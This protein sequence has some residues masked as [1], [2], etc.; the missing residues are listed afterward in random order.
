MQDPFSQISQQ[1]NM[2]NGALLFVSSQERV[3]ESGWETSTA[4]V[5]GSP[6]SN[7]W[8][9]ASVRAHIDSKLASAKIQPL[10]TSEHYYRAATL[11]CA[12]AVENMRALV[13]EVAPVSGATLLLGVDFHRTIYSEEAMKKVRAILL[14]AAAQIFAG[15]DLEKR[16]GDVNRVKAPVKDGSVVKVH[17]GGRFRL[18][19]CTPRWAA[20]QLSALVERAE[21]SPDAN[22]VAPLRESLAKGATRVEYL[23]KVQGIEGT[24]GD[25]LLAVPSNKGQEKQGETDSNAM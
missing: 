12:P 1:A 7:F 4:S 18:K 21:H 9:K 25:V 6:L 23:E 20:M 8:C 24:E 16:E 14:K 3:G 2:E 13:E 11:Q 22:W 5:A 17:R 10:P 15:A 19:I